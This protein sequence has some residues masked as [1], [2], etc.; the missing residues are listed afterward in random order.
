MAGVPGFEP[1]PSDLETVVLPGYTTPLQERSMK[2]ARLGEEM[3][4]FR[5]PGNQPAA[6]PCFG[7]LH[8]SELSW[9]RR[10]DLNLH[11]P[12]GE[13]FYRPLSYQFDLSCINTSKKGRYLVVKDPK[14]EKERGLSGWKA[15]P[16]LRQSQINLILRV[17]GAGVNPLPRCH[18]ALSLLRRMTLPFGSI[19]R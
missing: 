15:A 17:S 6:H 12:Q 11:T 8:P 14:T 19:F 7:L 3:G 13:R 16:L 18:T 5:W 9:C 10:Q 4:G 2:R 1:E